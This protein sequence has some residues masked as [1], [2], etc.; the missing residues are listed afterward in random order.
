MGNLLQVGFGTAGAEIIAKSLRADGELDPMVPGTRVH[1]IFCFCNIRNF[2]T[3]T[4]YLQEDVILFVNKL[5][6]ITHDHVVNSGGNPNKNVG[7]GFLLVWKLNSKDGK[8]DRLEK[9]VFDSALT[10]IQTI[11]SELKEIGP[12][13]Q[14]KKKESNRKS[15][16]NLKIEMGFGLHSGWAIEGSIGSKVKVDASYLSLHVN[17]ASRLEAATNKYH[18]PLLMSHAFVSGLTGS[19]QSTCRRADRVVLSDSNESITIFHHDMDTFQSLQ[20]K[21]KDYSDL[22]LAT[23]WK[24]KEEVIGE[25]INITEIIKSLQS[26]KTFLIR[27]VYD[28]AFN[29]YI[30]GNWKK[31]KILLHLWLE[32]FPGDILVQNLIRYLMR[33]DFI[34][35]DEWNGTEFLLK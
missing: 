5:A 16:P 33:H 7:N 34:C 25:A 8:R 9:H 21:P 13:A 14:F 23:S 32:K 2:I 31:C 6:K 35:P 1:A 27:E 11:R 17:L 22:I 4:E 20:N 10:C 12:I 3:V 29:S 30:D 19:L 24:N 15:D 26:D 28:A 18:V